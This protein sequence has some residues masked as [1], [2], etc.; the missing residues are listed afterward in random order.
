M[1]AKVKVNPMLDDGSNES[2][3]IEEIAGILGLV[4]RYQTVK[5]NVLS[6]EVETFQFMPLDV[7]IESLNGEFSKD[8]KVK[9]NPKRVPENYKV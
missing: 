5:V 9:I 8:I 1:I 4:E 6:N 3:L 7:T 2:F